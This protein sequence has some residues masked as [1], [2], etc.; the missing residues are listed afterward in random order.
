MIVT[1][2]VTVTLAALV[3]AWI[4]RRPEGVYGNHWGDPWFGPLTR[5][6]DVERD[7]E[8]QFWDKDR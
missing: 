3:I 7:A 2:A 5:P 1:L 6:W 8:D 4:A